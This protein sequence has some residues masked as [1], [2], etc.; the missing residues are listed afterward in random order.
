MQDKHFHSEGEE[1]KIEQEWLDWSKAETQQGKECTPRLHVQ[2]LTF[3]MEYSDQ[4]KASLYPTACSF[5]LW[6]FCI[7]GASV[8]G[9]LM[10]LA[11]LTS[12]GLHCNLGFIFT[13]S[14]SNILGHPCQTLTLP[15]IAKP[16]QLSGDIVQ[17]L[18]WESKLGRQV[19][20]QAPLLT[21][22]SC[23][24]SQMFPN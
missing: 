14:S 3:V 16:Q 20:Q 11:W 23:Q 6:L 4:Q 17:D 8:G 24:P 2:H 13:D 10:I 1:W 9:H 5:S 21:D 22:L 12:W 7:P 19:W 15:Y 18:S